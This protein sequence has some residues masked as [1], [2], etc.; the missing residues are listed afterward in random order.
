MNFLS[1]IN[2]KV[3]L[4]ELNIA[5]THDSATAYVSMENAARCQDKTIAEQLDMGVRFLDIRLTKKG[6]EFYL[7]HSLADCYSDKEKTKR[8]T[9]GEVLSD[10]KSFLSENPA[11]TV[12]VSIKQDRGII[13]RWFFPP[14]YNKY[15]KGDEDSWYLENKVPTLG[16]CRGKIVLMR[17][18]RV[19]KSFYKTAKGGLNFSFWPDQARK[20]T[21]AKRVKLSG[22]TDAVV[23]DR[24][25]LDL[26]TKWQ[27]S[28]HYLDIA[29][30]LPKKLAVHFISTSAKTNGTLV[31]TAEYINK[32]FMQYPL[33]KGTGWIICDF[34]SR[35]QIE[36]IMTSNT[37]KSE[38]I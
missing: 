21:T 11:E 13:N 33:K 31:G 34:P 32:E 26:K 7:I 18:C 25:G 12:I 35:E 28:K 8:L 2:D 17:R 27:C 38:E 30:T 24:Y 10:C 1:E 5:G 3:Y 16:E 6:D 22:D 19:W 29:E 15:I 14:F 9:F 36:K 37:E 20:K 4:S 23:Q